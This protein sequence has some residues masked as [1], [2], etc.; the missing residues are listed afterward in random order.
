MRVATSLCAIGVLGIVACVARADDLRPSA[1][2][3][4][5]TISVTPR[6]QTIPQGGNARFTASIQG[7]FDQF[8]LFQVVMS[9]LPCMGPGSINISAPPGTIDFTWMPN[10]Q[11]PAACPPGTYPVTFSYVIP[12]TPIQVGDVVTVIVAPPACQGDTNGDRVVDGADLSVLLGNFGSSVPTG[13]GGDLNGDGTVNGLDVS[14][15]LG[16]FGTVC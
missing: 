15:L 11:T 10:V 14:V 16:R 1:E 9:G 6:T 12:G 4:T 3:S 8:G 5:I 13:T 2:R 7:I